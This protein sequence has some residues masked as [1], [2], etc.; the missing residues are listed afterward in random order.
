MTESQIWDSIE[1]TDTCWNWTRFPTSNGYGL[2]QFDGKLRLVHRVIWNLKVGPIPNG[3]HI[4][5]LC[6]NRKCVNPAHLELVTPRENIL[7]GI[8][9]TAKNA[10]KTH[11]LRGHPLS[12]TNLHT[13]KSPTGRVWRSCRRC[14][15]EW[16]RNKLKC[17]KIR[18]HYAPR[19]T[20]AEK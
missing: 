5:H 20:K 18:G 3:L 12:G 19:V 14:K 16:L 8:G 4:D 9:I 17:I 1:K 10:V 6:R 15:Y 11:C 7:R 2:V 13:R